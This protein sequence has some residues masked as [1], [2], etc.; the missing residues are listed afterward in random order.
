[1]RKVIVLLLIGFFTDILFAQK[2]VRYFDT[3]YPDTLPKKYAS[4]I[5]SITNRFQESLT[6]SPDGNEQLFTQTSSVNWM[7]ERILRVKRT[8]NK[9]ILLDTLHFGINFM[10]VAEPMISN[11]NKKLFFLGDQ[12]CWY[13]NR[14]INGEW[15]NPIKLDSIL[16]REEYWFLRTIKNEVD[17]TTFFNY[18]KSMSV[19][20][21]PE[22]LSFKNAIEPGCDPYISSN[23]DYM[24]FSSFKKGGFGQGDLCVCFN[25]GFG[26][27]S[28]PYNLGPEINTEY[29]EYGP[30]ISPDGKYLFF[31]RREK[32][33]NASFSDIYW[34]SIKVIDKYRNAE[35]LIY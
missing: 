24:I 10:G 4:G 31:S 14:T 25:D 19:F 27:W 1:M 32:W 8:G 2:T 17:D 11:D 15:S 26:N 5:I 7:Q 33:E 18:T 28:K 35:K 22:Y 6:M 34:V 29:F 12:S 30:L 3:D 20:T 21:S 23:K 13:S 9:N 16:N